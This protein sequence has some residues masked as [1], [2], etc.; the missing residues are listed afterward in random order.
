MKKHIIWSVLLLAACKSGDGIVLPSVSG[1]AA[2]MNACI[3]KPYDILPASIEIDGLRDASQNGS[4]GMVLDRFL[5]GFAAITAD[6]N[7]ENIAKGSGLADKDPSIWGIRPLSKSSGQYVLGIS[8]YGSETCKD[9]E[10]I[11]IAQGNPKAMDYLQD[12]RFDQSLPRNWCISAVKSVSNPHY[13]YSVNDKAQSLSGATLHTKTETI[14]KSGELYARRTS[15]WL[16][17]PS[18]PIGV[19]NISKD[20]FGKVPQISPLIGKQGL[21][22]RPKNAPTLIARQ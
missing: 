18:F 4:A 22:L 9:F 5:D 6:I 17:Q 10:E 14:M 19:N 16:S 2:L 7:V 8:Q 20:C 15:I 3:A 13:S 21:V 11:I 1:E 12:Q